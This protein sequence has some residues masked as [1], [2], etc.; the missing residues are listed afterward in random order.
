EQRDHHLPAIAADAVDRD[1]ERAGEG[2]ARRENEAE[3]KNEDTNHGDLVLTW[4]SEK[5]A[6]PAWQAIA[7]LR[8]ATASVAPEASPRRMPRSKSGALP[9]MVTNGYA[10]A[11]RS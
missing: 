7:A 2:A 9:M 4:A 11:R 3:R 8:M 10:P 5:V 1:R 6:M